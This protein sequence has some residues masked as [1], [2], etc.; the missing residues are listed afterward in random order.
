MSSVTAATGDG[1]VPYCSL[2]YPRV[3]KE[4]NQAHGVRDR[5]IELIELEGSHHQKMLHED[6][7]SYLLIQQVAR[8]KGE[9]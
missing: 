9:Q 5:E 8:K 2:A 7:V 6:S 3:W 4:H 1:T